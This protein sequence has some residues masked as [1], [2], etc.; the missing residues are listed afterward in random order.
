MHELR[1]N[2]III[3]FMTLLIA[4][5]ALAAIAFAPGLPQEVELLL[6][7]TVGAAGASTI[8]LAA[9]VASPAPNHVKEVLDYHQTVIL[10][11]TEK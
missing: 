8:G 10:K 6:A 11:L 5:G 4:G 9:Q 7:A 1:P 2:I 3:A